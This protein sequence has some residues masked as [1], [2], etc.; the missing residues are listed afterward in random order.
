M[1]KSDRRRD[2]IL[3]RMTGQHM[4]SSMTGQDLKAARAE[5]GLYQRELAER[6]GVV[7]RTIAAW[8]GDERPIPQT[9]ILLVDRILADHR[10]RRVRQTA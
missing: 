10:K 2:P 7:W 1:K 5:L 4:I 6:L 3:T 9:A 8:E